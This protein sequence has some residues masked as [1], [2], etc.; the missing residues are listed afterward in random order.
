MQ[1][2]SAVTMKRRSMK[3][4][5]MGLFT[6][7]LIFIAA[8][9]GMCA[10]EKLAP[11]G[12]KQG[13]EIFV[14]TGHSNGVGFVAF[15]PD[16][17]YALSGSWDKTTRIWNIDS[18]KELTQLI[19]FTDGEWVVMTPDGYFNASP[20]GAKHINVRVG[21]NVYSIDNF[22]EKFFNPVYVASVLQGKMESYIRSEKISCSLQQSCI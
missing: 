4:L 5:A 19:S 15:S 16:G 12:S 2:T 10:A 22:Y 17:R 6:V 21:N 20:N 1:E 8:G 14:Q 9:V 13:P 3:T 11:A 18:G 7:G